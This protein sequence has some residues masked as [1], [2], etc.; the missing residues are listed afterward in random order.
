MGVPLLDL[1]AQYQELKDELD[2]AVFDV[3]SNAAFIGGPKVQELS[4][5]IA[6]YCGTQLRRPVRQAAP[7]RS[8]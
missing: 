1:K 4:E 7:T 2:A 5:A 8:S 3:M 6:E